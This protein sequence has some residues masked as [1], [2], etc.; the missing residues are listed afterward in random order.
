ML[1]MDST[2]FHRLCLCGQGR[3]G[4]VASL[5]LCLIPGAI[6]MLPL[7][8]SWYHDTI[9]C[10]LPCTVSLQGS[11]QQ[12]NQRSLQRILDASTGMDEVMSGPE[13]TTG[14]TVGADYHDWGVGGQQGS[15]EATF[16]PGNFT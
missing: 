8:V 7:Q 2:Y 12:A 11:R 10:L 15:M 3:E 14:H 4:R 9:C 6:A 16:A 13:R 1:A 5:Q